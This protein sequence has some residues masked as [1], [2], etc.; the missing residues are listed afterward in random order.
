VGGAGKMTVNPPGDVFEHE[1]DAI[2]QT[3]AGAGAG[4]EVQRQDLP[5]EEEELVQTQGIPEEE[6]EMAQT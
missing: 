1:A 2:A 5:E 3:I 6:E 4:A